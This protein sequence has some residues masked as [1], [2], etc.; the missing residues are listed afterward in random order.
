MNCPTLAVP[1]HSL[2][3]ERLVLSVLLAEGARA[4]GRIRASLDAGDFY[5]NGY[6]AIFAAIV[7]LDRGGRDIN[8]L[9]VHQEM[10]LQGALPKL[11][12]HAGG[13]HEMRPQAYLIDLAAAR[14]EIQGLEGF[15][16]IVRGQAVARR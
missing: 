10:E 9:T 7:E 16:S 8:P 15:A 3:A 2:Q 11:V 5:D 6:A 12:K 14:A 1:P 13:L 4:F